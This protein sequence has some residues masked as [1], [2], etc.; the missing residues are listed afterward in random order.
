VAIIGQSRGGNFAKVLA[1]R[2]PDLVSGI[3]TLGSPQLDPFDCHPFVR[4]QVQA[5]GALGSLGLP[6]LFSR[7]CRTGECC[8]SFWSD[9]KRPLR[10]DVGYLAVY[11]RSDGVV[12]WRACLDPHARQ[13]EIEA[14]HIGMAVAPRAWRA[15]QHALADFRVRDRK[16]AARRRGRARR[17]NAPRL[18]SVA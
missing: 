5:I 13:L 16:P 11:S 10:E 8:D 9:L 3:V 17:G 14:T 4:A 6:G 12:N 2:H 7:R 15:V 18:R 1:V